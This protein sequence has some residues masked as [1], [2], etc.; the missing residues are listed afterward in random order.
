[1]PAIQFPQ[2]IKL[3]KE[4]KQTLVTPRNKWK[5]LLYILLGYL[6][7]ASC[8][9]NGTMNPSSSLYFLFTFQSERKRALLHTVWWRRAGKSWRRTLL[10]D[11][12]DRGEDATHIGF[13]NLKPR[14]VCGGS[15]QRT[16]NKQER[17]LWKNILSAQIQTGLGLIER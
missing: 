15:T 14:V 1:M 17:F 11:T 10:H 2:K 3:F 12:A 13:T 8:N 9:M 7:R 4:L 16:K 6:N 5:F